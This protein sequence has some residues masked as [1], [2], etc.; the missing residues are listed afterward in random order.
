[1]GFMDER[2]A[3]RSSARASADKQRVS[4]A[5]LRR[6]LIFAPKS[7]PHPQIRPFTFPLLFPVWIH[8]QA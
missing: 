5:K 2:Y 3:S 4:G 6:F 7:P 8:V 1:M